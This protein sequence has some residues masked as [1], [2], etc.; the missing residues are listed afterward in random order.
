MKNFNE[1][2]LRHFSILFLQA[3]PFPYFEPDRVEQIYAD[4]NIVDFSK[5]VIVKQNNFNVLNGPVFLQTMLGNNFQVE[6]LI[7][8]QENGNKVQ[9][10]RHPPRPL[11]DF[12]ADDH[13]LYENLARQSDFPEDIRRNCPLLKVC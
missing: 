13:I 5:I 6:Y 10:F 7:F 2:N 8:R 4:T 11:C 9:V 1:N 3:D 12:F